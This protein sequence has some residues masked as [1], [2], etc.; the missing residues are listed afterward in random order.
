MDLHVFARILHVLAVVHWI[1]GVAMVTLVILPQLRLQPA[2]DRVASFE[3]IEGNFGGQ[4]KL[5]TLTAG[6]SGFWMLWL[7]DGWGL[8]LDGSYWWLW[9]MVVVWALF[10]TVLFV[11]EPLVLH[12]WFHARASRDA[13]GTFTLV[14][15]LHRILLA[16]S[17]LAVAGAVQGAHGGLW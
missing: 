6:I 5:S 2:A 8:L 14:L 10:T 12:R 1:G 7:T 9:L 3:A 17:A 16:L 15:R 11:L 13:E 4:A